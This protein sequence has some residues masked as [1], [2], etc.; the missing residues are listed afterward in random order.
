MADVG[1]IYGLMDPRYG[2]PRYIGQTTQKVNKRFTQHIRMALGGQHKRSYLCNWI[3]KL[4]TLGM[5]PIIYVI[6]HDVPIDTLNAREAYFVE[7]VTI[8]CEAVGLHCVN[9][10][11]GGDWGGKMAPQ[12]RK[13][14]S[15]THKI[16]QNKPEMLEA[17]RVRS[18]GKNNPM[19][20]RNDQ[21]YKPGGCVEANKKNKGKT[22]DEI[23]GEERAEEMRKKHRDGCLRFQGTPEQRKRNGDSHRGKTA[24]NK[25]LTKESNPIVAAAVAKSAASRIGLPTWN[26]GLTKETSPSV[27]KISAARRR[28]QQ[29]AGE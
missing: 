26:K 10:T 16:V 27:A 29:K 12:T 9:G 1:I 20:G 6:E 15:E 4:D 17:N 7:M 2:I 19:Y 14:M 8:A 25:G 28:G 3:R 24:W 5:Q 11:I 22:W 21:C 18:S 13:K 23:F